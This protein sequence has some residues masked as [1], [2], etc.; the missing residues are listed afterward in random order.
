MATL[1]LVKMG[2]M[3]LAGSKVVLICTCCAIVVCVYYE[4]NDSGG[5]VEDGICNFLFSRA[6]PGSA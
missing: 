4:N 6:K 5:G 2:W 3:T 1:P